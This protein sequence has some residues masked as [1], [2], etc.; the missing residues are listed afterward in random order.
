VTPR[1]GSR[2]RNHPNSRDRDG[3]TPLMFAAGQGRLDL[4]KVLLAHG[5][6]VEAKA[7]GGLTAWQLAT[8]EEVIAALREARGRR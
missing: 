6:D 3:L 5:A 7:A 4:V 2:E 8:E 1:V